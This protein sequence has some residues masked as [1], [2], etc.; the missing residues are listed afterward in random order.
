MYLESYLPTPQYVWFLRSLIPPK[1]YEQYGL[2]HYAEGDYVYAPINKAWYGLKGS[3]KIAHDDIVAHM[4]KHG[5]K[6][7]QTPGLFLHET[8]PISFTLIVDDFGI[9]YTDKKDVVHLKTCLEEIYTMK[10]D[11]EGKKYCG[12]DLKWDYDKREVLLSMDGYVE[13]A[14]KEFEHMIPKQTHHGPSKVDRPYYGAKVQYVQEDNTSPLT[15][16]EITYIKQVTGKFLFYGR[17]I[18]ITMQHV[19]NDIAIAST[20]ATNATMAATKYF[21]NY[22]ACN[23]DAAIRYQESDMILY[24]VSDAAYLVCPKA[25]SRAGGYHYMGNK[26]GKL[27]NEAVFVLEKVIKTSWPQQQKQK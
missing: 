20:N 2:D 22:A 16:E 21:L 3:G 11:W 13:A 12:I 24:V 5:Y 6:Q 15:P 25:R 14:L 8:R 18:D 27:F 26:D 4:A 10:I 17:G 23:Q 19:L 1:F 9:K 7:A